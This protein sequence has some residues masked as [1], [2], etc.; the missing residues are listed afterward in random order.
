M[1]F[2]IEQLYQFAS[3][4]LTFFLN[5]KLRQLGTIPR[6]LPR[7]ALRTLVHSFVSSRLD[8][9]NALFYGLSRCDIRILHSVQNAAPHLFGGLSKYDHVSPVLR[10]EL[11]W[12]PVAKRIDFKI[13]AIVYNCLHCVAPSYRIEICVPVLSSRSRSTVRGDLVVPRWKSVCYG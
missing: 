3:S 12:L 6:A 10:D 7:D 9:C 8:Y 13:A 5:R 4:N 11:D 1:S 2:G